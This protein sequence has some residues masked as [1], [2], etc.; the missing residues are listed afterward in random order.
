MIRKFTQRIIPITFNAKFRL[1]FYSNSTCILKFRMKY[2]LRILSHVANQSTFVTKVTAKTQIAK[3]TVLLKILIVAA[4]STSN[5]LYILNS[6][7]MIF[8]VIMAHSTCVVALTIN[9]L[10]FTSTYVVIATNS[11]LNTKF[12]VD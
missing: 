7:F 9:T 11:S 2:G 8:A 3:V 4:K 10:I 6:K 1:L 12:N 5:R